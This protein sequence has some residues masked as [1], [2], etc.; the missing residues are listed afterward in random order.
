MKE[1]I[2][3][4]NNQIFNVDNINITDGKNILNKDI[5]TLINVTVSGLF[6]ACHI[7]GISKLKKLFD[8]EANYIDQ[9]GLQLVNI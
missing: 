6:L 1:Y 2:E 5:N 3:I 4:C 9:N 8:K 7:F